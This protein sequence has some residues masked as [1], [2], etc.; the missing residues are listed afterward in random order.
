M[1]NFTPSKKFRIPT[2]AIVT[3]A[4]VFAAFLAIFI[5]KVKPGLVLNYGLLGV[6]IL[7]HF[8][9]HNGHGDDRG[10]QENKGIK[11]AANKLAP[12]PIEI[13]DPLNSRHG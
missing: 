10:H 13:D 2:L 7:I 1:N 12:V 3:I 11:S 9:M 8:F 4:G 6:M 5:F